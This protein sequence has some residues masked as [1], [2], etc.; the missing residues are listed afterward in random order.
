MNRTLNVVR[1]QL[2]NTQTYAWVPLLVM[3]SALVIS[4]AIFGILD[5]AGLDG[6]KYGGGLQAPLWYFLAV[7]IQALTLTFPFSQAMSV[8]RREFFAGTVLTAALSSLAQAVIVVIGGL[9]EQ[10]TGG[11][12]VNGYFF[13]LPWMWEAGPLGAALAFFSAAMF[14]FLAGFAAATIYKRFGALMVTAVLVGIALAL[15]GI[16]WLITATQSW[17]AIAEGL[18]GLSALGLAAIGLVASAALAGSSFLTL[19]RAIP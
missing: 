6:P 8:T 3:G 11:W 15:V 7:G 18:V 12:G 2:I 19:R 16:V 10:A 4:V 13:Y 17:Q 9:I 5:S 1:M 14:I